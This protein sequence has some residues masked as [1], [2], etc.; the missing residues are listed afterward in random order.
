VKIKIKRESFLSQFQIASMVAPSRSPKTILEYVK[1]SVQ[2]GGAVV[3]ATDMDIEVRLNIPD[4]EVE[5]PGD[6]V[7]P[8]ARL[9]LILR[10]SSDEQLVIELVEDKVLITGSN[11]KFELNSRNV[12]EFPEVDTNDQGG[13]FEI[14]SGAFK[15]LVRRTIFSTDA[16]SGRYALGG[17]LLEFEADQVIAVATDGRRLAKMSGGG[18]IHGELANAD[19]PTIVP[20]KTMHLI[21]RVLDESDEKVQLSPRSNDLIVKFPNGILY[22]RLVEGKFPK[23]REVIPTRSSSHKLEIPVGPLYSAIRQAA[24]VASSESRGIDFTFA[25]GTLTLDSITAEVGTSRIQMPVAYDDNELT[26]TLDHRFFGDF[27]RVLE[28]E[29]TFTF[30][31]EASD[32]AAYCKTDDGYSYVI[33]PL[34]KERRGH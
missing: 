6:V 13:Y 5:T 8:V 21:E 31:I 22:S 26:I 14:S 33:M 11:S 1:L 19:S 18:S 24:I 9:S 29:K 15:E 32:K 23:W 16:E 12:D 2:P 34:S 28:P 20:A 17:I 27:L 4:I 25:D 30:D 10:E 7:I 3:T